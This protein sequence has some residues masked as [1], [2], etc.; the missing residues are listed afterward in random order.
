MSSL[1]QLKTGSNARRRRNVLAGRGEDLVHHRARRPVRHPDAPAGAADAQ[2]LVRD[3]LLVGREHRAERRHDDVVGAVLE[4][5]VLRVRDL[6][7]HR[8]P[9]GL[10]AVLRLLEQLRDEVGA[11]DV[12]ETARG[13]ERGR[14]GPAAD[15]EHALAGMDVDALEHQLAVEDEHRAEAAE[16]PLRPDPL[17]PLGDSLVV[18]CRCAHVRPPSSPSSERGSSLTPRHRRR[19]TL[20]G[21]Y[22]LA[23][24]EARP[25]VPAQN[26]RERRARL[27]LERCASAGVDPLRLELP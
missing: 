14:A 12:C 21:S 20:L 2:E 22:G 26:P 11:R 19:H 9:F 4:G 5:K 23:D 24:D 27:G 18:R 6:R 17:L 16:I 13:R 1:P 25:W 10:R 3:A 15:V 7:L 8:Q